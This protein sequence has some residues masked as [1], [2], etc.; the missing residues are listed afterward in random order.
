MPG[1][2]NKAHARQARQSKPNPPPTD[3]QTK[4][5][6]SKKQYGKR[7]HCTHTHKT[8]SQIGHTKTRQAELER[9][10]IKPRRLSPTCI[11]KTT[12]QAAADKAAT[13]TEVD[14]N[15]PYGAFTLHQAQPTQSAGLRTT[16]HFAISD[17][18]RIPV[19]NVYHDLVER[20]SKIIRIACDKFAH[21]L[22]PLRLDVP[23]CG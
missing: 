11:E 20:R 18:E 10:I 12:Q 8:K 15:F 3:L 1:Y 13:N 2:K 9:E 4:A 5:M 21:P 7:R 16:A 14:E 6:K 17:H 23:M 19:F 22:K